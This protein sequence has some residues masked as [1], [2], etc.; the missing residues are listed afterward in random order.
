MPVSRLLPYL[1][2]LLALLAAAAWYVWQRSQASVEEKIDLPVFQA[3]P[4]ARV[5]SFIFSLYECSDDR[6]AFATIDGQLYYYSISDGSLTKADKVSELGQLLH[7]GEGGPVYTNDS[8]VIRGTINSA[9]LKVLF[10]SSDT[11]AGCSVAQGRLFPAYLSTSGPL[12][13]IELSSAKKSVLLN[14][15]LPLRYVAAAAP[16]Q[17]LLLVL[18]GG[19]FAEFDYGAKA[20]RF[21]QDVGSPL[22]LDRCCGDAD[23]AVAVGMDATAKVYSRRTRQ[24]SLLES[25]Y[26]GRRK[27]DHVRVSRGRLL[28]ACEALGSRRTVVVALDLETGRRQDV[29]VFKGAIMDLIVPADRPN[30]LYFVAGG[31]LH[32]SALP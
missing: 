23:Y 25:P 32:R 27:A 18:E 10:E 24:V 19:R 7:C 16:G 12:C 13:E 22:F 21:V 17:P 2:G 14:Q 3:A 28:V 30:E 29:L 5:D 9:N 8:R 31:E 15:S 1:V 6:L 4:L 20:L 26:K 11:L